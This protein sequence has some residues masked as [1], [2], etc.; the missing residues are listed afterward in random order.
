MKR[1]GS[2]FDNNLALEVHSL[3]GSSAFALSVFCSGVAPRGSHDHWELY[4]RLRIDGSIDTH[5]N[6]TCRFNLFNETH[7]NHPLNFPNIP[8][9][10]FTRRKE[11]KPASALATT[12][13]LRFL[14]SIPD[15]FKPDT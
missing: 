4:G 10:V 2:R 14:L 15:S 7:E 11:T 3:R 8:K 1:R 12:K 6:I 5:C 13:V 9:P